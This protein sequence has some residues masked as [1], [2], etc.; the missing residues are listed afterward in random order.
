M[1]FTHDGMPVK[2]TDVPLAVCA[3]INV[4]GCDS[5]VGVTVAELPVT[6]AVPVIAGTVSV[7]VDAVLGVSRV[8]EPPPDELSFNGIS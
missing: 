5:I 4:N 6:T 2:S 1:R 8:T 7:N 3:V